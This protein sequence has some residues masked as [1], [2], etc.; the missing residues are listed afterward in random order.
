M[1]ARIAALVVA[2]AMVITAIAVRARWDDDNGGSGGDGD[3]RSG[4]LRLVCAPEVERACEA[5]AEEAGEDVEVVVEQAGATADRLASGADTGAAD[6][7][8][9]L[10]PGP[11]PEIV[12]TLR[13]GR[14]ALFAPAGA[15]IAHGRAG[16]VIWND[17]HA[18]L[19]QHCGGAVTWACVGDVA[20][21]EWT[22]AGGDA[23]WGRVRFA[24]RDPA[25]TA[26]GLAVLG[27][28]TAGV[29]G[30]TDV[31]LLDLD[32]ERFGTWLANLARARVAIDLE[33]MLTQGPAAAAGLATLDAVAS[34]VL[35]SA[36]RRD[37]V[38]LIYPA[39]VATVGVVLARVPG[40]RGD[41]LRELVDA[42][43]SGAL[44]AS[45]WGAPAG[46]GLP[47]PGLLHALR[48]RWASV[49]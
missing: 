43:G 28:G 33:R 40:G 41:R 30:R 8:G 36:A 44:R 42:H 21:R 2:V 32:D 39:P 20:G 47:S 37:Q 6:L 49:R 29:F 25:S 48:E 24:L 13:S 7:D 23:N 11:W 45:G 3:G 31:V 19:A 35:A 15:P 10:V 5:I 38:R 46:A 12:D 34:P 1:A 14:P 16:L 27:A 18:R 4:P 22:D 9:W 26:A 17:R